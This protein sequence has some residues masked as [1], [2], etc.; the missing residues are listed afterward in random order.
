MST[1]R[2]EVG[3]RSLSFFFF[4][5]PLSEIT[6]TSR[7]VFTYLIN[8]LPNALGY[9]VVVFFLTSIC[10]KRDHT[11]ARAATSARRHRADFCQ[12]ISSSQ[13][14]AKRVFLYPCHVFYTGLFV[15]S[16]IYASPACF[17]VPADAHS[18]IPPS[19]LLRCLFLPSCFSC[20]LNR[21]VLI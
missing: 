1:S 7:G 14:G 4:L 5:T 16:F 13:T 9:C 10:E 19:L 8:L 17:C 15:H 11:T 2:Q 3:I 20:L 18:P 21:D 6:A 12:T